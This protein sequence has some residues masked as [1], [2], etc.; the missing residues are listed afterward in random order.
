MKHILN[1]N[2]SNIIVDAIKTYIERGDYYVAFSK[3]GNKSIELCDSEDLSYQL[4]R[5][6][7]FNHK[8]ISSNKE[9]HSG[10]AIYNGSVVINPELGKDLLRIDCIKNILSKSL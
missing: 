10:T 2:G 5:T 6:S 4:N 9:I 7:K 8:I 1:Y 3:N